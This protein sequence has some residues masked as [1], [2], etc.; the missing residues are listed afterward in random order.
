[1]ESVEGDADGQN[2]L[3]GVYAGVK[4]PGHQ[5]G[6]EVFGEKIEVFE[7]AEET[8]IEE[9]AP[10]QDVLSPS[11]TGGPVEHFADIE[12]HGSGYK[13]ER[14]KAVVPRRVKGVARDK[15]EGILRPPRQSS[16][17]QPDEREKESKLDRVKKH[18]LEAQ[19]RL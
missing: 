7:E 12:I 10:I 11:V 3:E 9:N 6:L 8:E 17:E 19:Q 5:Q 18:Q 14:Q 15:E 4:A 2:D 1:M 16:V 13:D